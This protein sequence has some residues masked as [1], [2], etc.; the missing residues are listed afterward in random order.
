MNDNPIRQAI[1]LHDNITTL[2]QL[3]H[4]AMTADPERSDR[5]LDSIREALNTQL[6]RAQAEL[7]A[8]INLYG[9]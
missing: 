4:A 1:R 7:N 6:T 3:K 9:G 5:G 8:L 2:T